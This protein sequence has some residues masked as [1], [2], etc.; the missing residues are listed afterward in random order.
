[1]EMTGQFHFALVPS[2]DEQAFVDAMRKDVFGVL[3]STR[4]TRGFDHVL[5]KGPTPGQYM[6]QARVDLMSD[7]GYDFSAD[8]PQVQKAVKNHAV[9]IGVDA[10]ENI[11]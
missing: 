8:A 3:R 4:I 7:H 1:M 9:L 2:S 6:W 11:G 10:F 5:L